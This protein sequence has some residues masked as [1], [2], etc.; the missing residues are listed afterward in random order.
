MAFVHENV[1]Y[2]LVMS[3]PDLYLTNV[4]VETRCRCL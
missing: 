3:L 2:A 4:L 1:G